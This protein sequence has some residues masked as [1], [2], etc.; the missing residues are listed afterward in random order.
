LKPFVDRKYRT[1]REATATGVGGSSLAGL[2]T[3]CVGLWYPDIFSRLLVMSPSVWW[4]DGVV[5]KTVEELDRK[6]PLKIWLDTGTA[7]PGWENTRKLRDLLIDKGWR[8][9]DDLQYMEDEKASH[10]E[11]TWGRRVDPALRF[12]FPAQLPLR[13]GQ[14]RPK[15]PLVLERQF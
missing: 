6:L 11:A 3:M 13:F 12:L 8:V 14:R 5:L 15:P 7:E 4:D 9:D 10:T 2:L 1:R